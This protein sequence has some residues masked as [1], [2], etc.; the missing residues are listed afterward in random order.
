MSMPEQVIASKVA[1]ALVVEAEM[2][3]GPAAEVAL[4]PNRAVENPV[5]WFRRFNGGLWVGG[6]ATLTTQRLRFEANSLNKMVHSGPMEVDVELRHVV[7][8]SVRRGLFTSVIHVLLPGADFQL[9]CYGA[10]AFA[11]Q[12]REAM[13]GG[14]PAA[15]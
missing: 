3:M 10:R 13:R 15:R 11:E 9:R 6:R 4:S 14:R 7:D 5:E 8:V 12:I 2:A 1:N